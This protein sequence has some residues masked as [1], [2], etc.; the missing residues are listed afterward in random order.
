MISHEQLVAALAKP[1]SQIA[2]EIQAGEAHLAHMALGVAGEAGEVVDL[3]KKH[4][5][6]HKPLDH[7]KVV[8]EL[9]DMLF[10]VQG[11]CQEIGVD[12]QQILRH[13]IAKLTHRYGSA[14]SDQ[15]AIARVDVK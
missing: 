7:D 4:V 1:G 15:A 3:I 10:Y 6:Y 14:Y 9:G 2:Y 8:E 12:L 11:I 13:N 5:I